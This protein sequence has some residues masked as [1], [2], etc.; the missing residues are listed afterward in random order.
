MTLPEDLP[1][2][3]TQGRFAS[4][5]KILSREQINEHFMQK[6]N[7]TLKYDGTSKPRVGHL[8]ECELSS[9]ETTLLIGMK[10]QAGGTGEEYVNSITESISAA[11][12]N[13]LKGIQNTMTDRA[14]VNTCIDKKLS[15][16]TNENINSFR[17]GMHPLDT[18]AKSCDRALKENETPGHHPRLFKR[19]GESSVSC[20]LRKAADLFHNA[21]TGCAIELTSYLKSV[22]CPFTTLPRWV[23]NRFNILFDS[24]KCILS[25]TPY[26]LNY[27]R[28][29]SK[30]TNDLQS[31]VYQYLQCPH[32][33]SSLLCLAAISTRITQPW[34]EMINVAENI[35]ST[36]AMY[37]NAV[38]K[39]VSWKEEPREMLDV[40]SE[41]AIFAEVKPEQRSFLLNRDEDELSAACPTLKKMLHEC[42]TVCKRQLT[43][44][45]EGGLFW[46]PSDELLE[47]AS[48]C[49]ATNISGERQFAKADSLLN[50]ARNI[51]VAK[52]ESKLMFSANNTSDWL[53]SKSVDERK[54]KI[55][56]AMRKGKSVR[57]EDRKQKETVIKSIKERNEARRSH[58]TEKEQKHRDKLEET[59]EQVIN[60][61]VECGDIVDNGN[62]KR[63]SIASQKKFL[64]G[65]IRFREAINN[66]TKHALSKCTVEELKKIL[67]E[68]LGK[69]C[70]VNFCEVVN[71]LKNPE[72]FVH[73]NI[74][75][76]WEDASSIDIWWSGY[77]RSY[78][79]DEFEVKYEQAKELF[80]MT[81]SEIICDLLS[82]DLRFV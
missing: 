30:P 51:S 8:V 4:E 68:E 81:L 34:M 17:C 79:D 66:S 59:I 52:L 74:T 3:Q 6:R 7:T 50:K 10:Q 22:D 43:D 55:L 57:E 19:R 12:P 23:G 71:C 1:S 44:Q 20:L 39:M 38:E 69:A 40:N 13:L 27:F 63:K 5:M 65:Q 53:Q 29:V 64:T 41:S 56:L 75:Q 58:L 9:G 47:T 73:R 24:A 48:S 72:L 28:K 15:E 25:M 14:T 21:A 36:N 60:D 54:E 31:V 16:H 26:L 77:V 70:D 49:S 82:L 76:K 33:Q 61:G 46:Q 80:Y 37:Q 11:H 78:N 67:S 18:L 42:I 62:F 35:L 32:M 2:R 45:L